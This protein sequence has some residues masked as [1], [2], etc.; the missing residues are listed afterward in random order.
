MKTRN[1]DFE[2]PVTRRTLAEYCFPG[3]YGH[4]AVRRLRRWIACDTALRADLQSAGCYPHQ[5]LFS[6][7]QVE[8]FLKYFG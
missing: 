6:R 4:S 2:Y 3:S 8:V 7:H 5:K 1:L